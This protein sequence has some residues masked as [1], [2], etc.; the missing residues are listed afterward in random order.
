MKLEWM[1]E[2]RDILESLIHYC[3]I[4]YSAYKPEKFEY[5]GVTYSFS[6]IQVVEYLIE[7]EERKD[8]MNAVATRLG[9]SRSNF[10][11]LVKRLEEKGVVAKGVREGNQKD[12]LLEVTP[13]GKELYFH[14]AQQILDYHFS[15]MFAEFDQIPKEYIEAFSRGLKAAVPSV[16]KEEKEKEEGEV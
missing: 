1:G 2:Y 9:I 7:N 15:K 8:N 13:F 14:Y 3:N 5:E 12:V 4:Y 6:L 16:K 10:T 11:K